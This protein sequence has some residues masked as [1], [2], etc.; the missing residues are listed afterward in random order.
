M[1]SIFG[2]MTSSVTMSGGV[3]RIISMASLPSRACM[4]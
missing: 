1:P 4:T 3:A 2:I